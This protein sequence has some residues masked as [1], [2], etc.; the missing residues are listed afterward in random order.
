[1]NLFPFSEIS[2]ADLVVDA[3]YEGGT[4]G[5][6]ADDPISKLLPGCGNQ[7]GFRAAG[8]KANKKFVV[9]YTSGEDKDWP[10]SLDIHTGQFIYYGDNKTPGEELHSKAG[11][12]ILRRV[13][14]HLH[15]T[16][17]ELSSIPPFLVFQKYPTTGSSRSVQF[18]G[19]AVPGY[20]ALPATAD[21][22]A[23]WKTTGGQRFQNYRATMT[24]LNAAA[25]KRSWVNELTDEAPNHDLAPDVWRDWIASGRYI[26]LT[27]EPTT[28][29]LDVDQQTPDTPSKKAILNT[30]W[31]YFKD[32]PHGFEAFAARIYQMHDAHVIIDEITRAAVDGGRDAIGRY[33]LGLPEDPIYAEFALEAKAT[34]P[35]HPEKL[36]PPLVSVKSHD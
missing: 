24:V 30:V 7:G 9:L 14:D 6:A 3:I 4:F 18:K 8:K 5:N 34:G 23:V 35:A 33:L 27:A 13:F 36:R 16:P 25:I 17:H 19:L 32:R 20:P 29:I 28:I 1:M 15:H 21:L 12:Q 31:E 22:I 11:N 10:D 2:S 26:P